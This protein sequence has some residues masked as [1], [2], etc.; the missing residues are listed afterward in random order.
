MRHTASP[1][2]TELSY[3]RALLLPLPELSTYL[4]DPPREVAALLGCPCGQLGD[5]D[6]AALLR[7]RCYVEVGV[8][9]LACAIEREPG[10]PRPHALRELLLLDDDAWDIDPGALRV[11]QAFAH[12]RAWHLGLPSH[13]VRRFAALAPRPLRWT[14][15]EVERY[16]LNQA[17]GGYSGGLASLNMVRRLAVA[18]NNGVPVA[19]AAGGRTATLTTVADLTRH[20]IAELA[21]DPL[22]HENFDNRLYAL[23]EAEV[24]ITA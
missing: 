13:L 12:D 18:L 24:R 10:R 4:Y 7:G 2:P 1:V 3:D 14:D 20:V 15:A 9:L 11:V 23:V 6:H 17:F 19:L 21:P 8:R 22:D 16:A 5:D